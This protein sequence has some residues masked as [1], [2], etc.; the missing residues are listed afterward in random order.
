MAVEPEIPIERFEVFAMGI[1]HPEC[2]A[3]DSNGTL[4]CGGEAGQI[5]RI[6]ESGKAEI[7]TTLNGFVGG[8][9]FS[10]E[11]VLFA[12]CP[13][14]GI[15]RVEKSGAHEVFATA[16][17]DHKIVCPNFGVFDRAGN[18]YVT[19]CGKFR[20]RNGHLL[21]FRPDGAG[22]VLTGPIGYANGLALSA[23]ERT[24]YMVESDTN[25]VWRFRIGDDGSVDVPEV[26]VTEAGRLP[27]GLAL[28]TEDNLYISC[29]ASDEIFRV[30]PG[31]DKFLFAHDPWAIL[32]GAPTN[33]AFGGPDMDWIYVANLARTTITRA[34]VGRRGQQLVNQ[35][36]R[37]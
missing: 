7:V 22:E 10:P 20:D 4:W 29:Y 11:D 31:G 37:P 8:I 13:M 1:D 26:F 23:D 24:L 28:D 5:Y 19:D 14:M 17:G 27:D 16:A 25:S 2:V 36:T 21:R 12:C 32:L 18:Y 3:F 35:R 9:A 30:T 15:V 34:H 6:G 33:M